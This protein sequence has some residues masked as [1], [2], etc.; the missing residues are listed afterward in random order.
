MFPE[1]ETRARGFAVVEEQARGPVVREDARR[2]RASVR[3][4][5][6]ST[7]TRASEKKKRS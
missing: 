4:D 6:R 3:G 7:V 2:E 5:S 1:S